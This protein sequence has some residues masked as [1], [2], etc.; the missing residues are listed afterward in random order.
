MTTG[1]DPLEDLYVALFFFARRFSVRNPPSRRVS[2]ERTCLFGS[3]VGFPVRFDGS[4]SLQLL[5]DRIPGNLCDNQI[6]LE[7]DDFPV[8]ELGYHELFLRFIAQRFR[9]VLFS[10]NGHGCH[11]FFLFT[12][13]GMPNE[14]GA[15]CDN[16]LQCN[17][18][19]L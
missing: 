5:N 11:W 9:I 6:S 10:V 8:T 2:F 16:R 15:A 3:C 13:G 14:S 1:F 4:K 19:F 18:N 17:Y 12:V 7:V